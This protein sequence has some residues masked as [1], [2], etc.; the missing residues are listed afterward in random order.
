MATESRQ[1]DPSLTPEPAA[2][3]AHAPLPDKLRERPWDFSFFQAVRLLQL[4]TGN[5]DPIGSFDKPAT[6]AVRL[7]THPSISF[8]AAEIQSLKERPDQPP[9]MSVNFFGVDGPLGTLPTRYTELV[10]ERLYSRDSTLRDFL[11]IFNHR[12]ISLLYRAWEKYRFP[13][14]YER[15]RDDRTTGYLLDF[16]GLG[17]KGLANRQAI[18]D[19]ALIAYS[20]LLMQFPRSAAAFRN[21]LAHYFTVPVEVEPFAGGWR[22][23]DEGSRTVF[24]DGFS[25]NEQLGIGMVLGDEIWDQQS[26]VRVRLGPLTLAQYRSFLPDG[27]AHEPLKALSRFFC[28][29][30]LDVEVQLVLKRSEAPRFNLGAPDAEPPKLGWLGWIYSKPLTEDP[31]QTVFRLWE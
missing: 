29:E 23:L 10:I 21:M 28:G 1:P 14:A 3:E 11:D 20:G 30:D 31:D 9:K 17:T 25:R 7:G 24:Q 2:P 12:M 18:P 6:E 16:L 19:Q 15:T 13:V 27:D 8:P 26:I 4:T 5:T 22:K